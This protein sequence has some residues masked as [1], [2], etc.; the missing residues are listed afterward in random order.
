[1]DRAL[2]GQNCVCK[3][4][5][6]RQRGR[7]ARNSTPDPV[8]PLCGLSTLRDRRLLPPTATFLDMSGYDSPEH[9]RETIWPEAQLFLQNRGGSKR[10]GRGPPEGMETM[11][12]CQVETEE[13][14][15][16]VPHLHLPA[17]KPLG[18]SSLTGLQDSSAT[19]P[20]HRRAPAG[21]RGP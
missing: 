9:L 19:L 5:T 16:A 8:E 21:G 20:H 14:S 10:L 11:G 6:S 12:S 13:A 1:M 18:P 4:G 15:G 2:L 3:K 17:S 7:W